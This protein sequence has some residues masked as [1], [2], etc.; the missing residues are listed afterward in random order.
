MWRS[1]VP[2]HLFERIVKE[3][4]PARLGAARKVVLDDLPLLL[5]IPR[6]LRSELQVELYAKCLTKHSFFSILEL[7]ETHTISELCTLAIEQTCLSGTEDIFN[8]G[9]IAVAAYILRTG[10][11]RYTQIM[12]GS[13]HNDQEVELRAGS[14]M[15][16]AELALWSHWSHR[17]FADAMGHCELINLKAEQLEVVF[18]KYSTVRLLVNDFCRTVCGY[19]S[20]MAGQKASDLPLHMAPLQL[21][22]YR[23]ILQMPVE[24]RMSISTALFE[25]HVAQPVPFRPLRFFKK[26]LDHLREEIE[27]GKCILTLDDHG[28]LLRVVEIA[29]LRISCSGKVLVNMGRIDFTEQSGK[30]QVIC[31]LPATKLKRGESPEAAVLRLVE[32]ELEGLAS[33]FSLRPLEREQFVEESVSKSYGMHTKY[34]RRIFEAELLNA[35]ECIVRVLEVKDKKNGG[36]DQFHSSHPVRREERFDPE[37]IVSAL[38]L[39]GDVCMKPMVVHA[40]ME[41]DDI[42]ALKQHR[43]YLTTWLSELSPVFHFENMSTLASKAVPSVPLAPIPILQTAGSRALEGF[44]ASRRMPTIGSISFSPQGSLS[45]QDADPP[46]SSVNLSYIQR[47]RIGTKSRSAISASGSSLF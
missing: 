17:G 29:C 12:H 22:R 31:D 46:L 43:A 28:K 32:E 37:H 7:V 14:D 41:P 1:E 20:S 21:E 13:K 10:R 8:Q 47:S 42:P 40:W 5:S 3:L 38:D 11:L 4:S 16:V 34:L 25:V 2:R 19:I 9:E 6:R 15:W 36:V 30:T 44:R 39:A 27:E 26:N 33:S 24:T 45:S 35:E 18:I 23:I